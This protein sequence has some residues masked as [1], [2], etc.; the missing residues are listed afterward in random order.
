MI[1]CLVEIIKVEK[2]HLLPCNDNIDNFINKDNKKIKKLK[3]NQ[4][5]LRQFKILLKNSMLL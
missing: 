4:L 2:Q 3:N 1:T 5:N